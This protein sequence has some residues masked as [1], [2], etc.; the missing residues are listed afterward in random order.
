MDTTILALNTLFMIDSLQGFTE[1]VGVPR[2][3]LRWSCSLT[4]FKAL[5]G[6]LVSVSLAQQCILEGKS[7]RYV[8][9]LL[10]LYEDELISRVEIG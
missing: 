3:L 4:A 5:R 8:F 9:L 6:F 1:K 10:G 2:A 7:N